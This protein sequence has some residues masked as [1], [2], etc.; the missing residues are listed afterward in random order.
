MTLAI[1]FSPFRQWRARSARMCQRITLLGVLIFMLAATVNAAAITQEFELDIPQQ[2]LSAALLALA[3]ATGVQLL[4]PSDL[5]QGLSGSALLGSYTTERA[6]AELLAGHGLSFRQTAPGTIS[7]E[8]LAETKDSVQT[9]PAVNVID[10]REVS[11]NGS[12]DPFATENSGSYA[13]AGSSLGGTAPALLKDIPRAISVLG[14]TEIRDQGLIEVVDALKA[15]PGVFGIDTSGH[16]SLP[17]VRSFAISRYQYDGG[18][19]SGDDFG[20]VRIQGDLSAY[21]RVELLR[22]GDGLGSGYSSPGGVINFVRKRPLDHQQLI[23]QG[24][25][26]SWDDYRAMLD[27]SSP[28]GWDG[29]LRGRLVFFGTDQRAFRDEEE[30]QREAWY[31]VVEADLTPTTLFSLGTQHSHQEAVPFTALTLPTYTDGTQVGWPRST[32]YLLPWHYADDWRR[33][34]F[35]TID[36]AFGPQ[37]NARL[38]LGHENNDQNSQLSFVDGRIDPLTGEGVRLANIRFGYQRE[39]TTV[40]LKVGGRFDWR[41]MEQQLSFRVSTQRQK[42]HDHA[43]LGD[44]L[45]YP[46]DVFD[47]DPADY[48]QPSFPADPDP[49]AFFRTHSHNASASVTLSFWDPLKVTGAWRWDSFEFE[50][51]PSAN[52]HFDGP[53]YLGMNYRLNPQWNAYASWTDVYESQDFYRTESGGRLSPT[54]GSSYDLGL[55]FTAADGSLNALL[56]LYRIEQRDFARRVSGETDDCCF[57]NGSDIF[58]YSQGFEAELSGTVRPDWQLSLSY[59]YSSGRQEGSDSINPGGPLDDTTPRHRFKLWTLWQPLRADRWRALRIGGGLRAQ[60]RGSYSA[61]NPRDLDEGFVSQ[62]GYAVFDALVGWRFD[63]QWDASLN[64]R[65][66]LDRVYYSTFDP[67]QFSANLYGEPR[68]F[69]LTLRATY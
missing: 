46:L 8:K 15:M 54:I 28:L 58:L 12:R 55:K 30:L 39:Y 5:L 33:N 47:F 27:A 22:G 56:A 25:A 21:D 16:E 24:S 19:V 67:N 18:A 61:V 51:F 68:S 35:A 64:L 48:P 69:L 17:L 53:S 57:D 65:N 6:L 1:A 13:A 42:G 7:I 63:E 10:R 62:G 9:L 59:S 31:G 49:D 40:D 38:V 32:S 52:R 29:R 23:V 3:E 36:Q 4:Y 14:Q 20:I 43:V 50:D 45:L 11:A 26:G 2:D 34:T 44:P 37:W 60:T 41:G 66:L